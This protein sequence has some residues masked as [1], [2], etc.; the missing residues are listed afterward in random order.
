MILQGIRS[1]GLGFNVSLFKP[2]IGKY[3][4]SKY[5]NKKVLDY[6]AGWGARCLGALSLGL[7]YYGIDPLTASNVD[8]MIKFYNGKGFVINNESENTK[9]Y[10]DIPMVDCI[11]SCPP[12]FDLELYSED[13]T[14]SVVK[15]SNYNDWIGKYWNN[16][17]K[18]CLKL[19]LDNG[20][21]I[22]IMKDVVGKYNIGD[23]MLKI[24]L[25]NGIKIVEK[26]YYKTSK[27]H[28]SGK[29]KTGKKDKNNEIV[30]VFKKS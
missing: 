22:L 2:L 17:V 14:Q 19:L 6:S 9:S 12:Y 10:K 3:L 7:E 27:N 28:L 25:D 11:L 29:A 21:F 5:A 20:Y 15:Y 16:T 30:F 26:L 4:Y 18:N 24:C 13:E 23:D 1:T 8:E